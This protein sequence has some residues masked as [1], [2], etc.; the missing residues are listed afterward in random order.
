[1]GWHAVTPRIV[2]DD[3][4]GLVAFVRDIFSATGEL[5]PDRP[6]VLA[7]GDARIMISGTGARPATTAFL[8]VYVDDADATFRRAIAA[9]ARSIEEPPAEPAIRRRERRMCDRRG[10]PSR[11]IGQPWHACHATLDAEHAQDR[12]RTGI[13]ARLTWQ[14]YGRA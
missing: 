9:G 5:T 2:V 13:A 4:A 11:P 1:M 8:Y 10:P 14:A 7:I 6:A 12:E 3:V